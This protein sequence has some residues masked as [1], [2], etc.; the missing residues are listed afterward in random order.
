MKQILITFLLL[1]P[2]ALQA[3]SI[4]QVKFGDEVFSTGLPEIIDTYYNSE[5]GEY[6]KMSKERR[7]T[8]LE[9]IEWTFGKVASY[10]EGMNECQGFHFFFVALISGDEISFDDG[11]LSDYTIVSP[12]FLVAADMFDGG[13]RVGQKPNMKYKE[14]VILKQREDDPSR[15]DYYWEDSEVYG[16]FTLDEDGKIKEIGLWV[17]DC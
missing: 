3:Q 5:T 14:G 17:N 2:V 16:H 12:R 13:L 4:G 10:E 8:A 11:C 6:I 1:L 7:E 15:Y 9:C